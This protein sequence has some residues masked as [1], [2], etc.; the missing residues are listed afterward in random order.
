MGIFTILSKGGTTIKPLKVCLHGKSCPAI[1]VENSR[2]MCGVA[3][4]PIFDMTE[5]PRGFWA[6][7]CQ[8]RKDTSRVTWCHDCPS[9][10][11]R[12]VDGDSVLFCN[13]AGKPVIDLKKC[14]KENW[15]RG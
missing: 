9:G 15:E 5:C 6:G 13:E 11:R 14:P 4:Q 12:V 2:Q 7:C 8:V 1:Y 10:E 3:K